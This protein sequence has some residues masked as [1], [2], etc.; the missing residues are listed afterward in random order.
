MPSLA[1]RNVLH[2]KVRLTVTLTGVILRK[3][4][5]SGES[6]S[7]MRDT[8][9][10]TVA[11]L[12][13]MRVRMDVNETD[14]G[15]IQMGQQAYVTADALGQVR[16]YGRVVRIGQIPGRKNIR[17]DGPSEPVDTKI[18]ETLIVLEDG[19]K[20]SPGLREDSSIITSTSSEASARGEKKATT[21]LD[22]E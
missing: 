6:L 10:V 2:D 19:K 12:N 9:I 7:V 16:F 15:K 11:N 21:L 20:L 1:R 18:L 22:L 13:K 8:P 4:V 5:K 17:T 14:V 3:Q